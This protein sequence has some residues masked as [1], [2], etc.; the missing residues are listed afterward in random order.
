MTDLLQRT[1]TRRLLLGAAL[2]AAGCGGGGASPGN[3]G[4]TTTGSTSSATGGAGGGTTS[5][6]VAC[7][8]QPAN[9]ALGGT[10]AAYGQLSVK[11]MGMPGGAITICPADQV[12]AATLLLL[13]TATQNAADPT[14]IDQVS[15]TLCSLTLPTV[16]ALVGTCNPSSQALVSTQIIAPAGL[17]AALPKVA[18]AT[19]TGTVGG[20]TPGS[21]ITMSPLDVVV[22]STKSGSMM[23]SWNTMT[24]GCSASGIG[25]TNACDTACVADCASL[26][27][28]DMDGYPGVTV[29]VCGETQSDKNLTCNASMPSKA[30]VTLQGEAFIDIEVNPTFSGTAVSS[31]ELS[32]TVDSE[33]LYHVVGAD[34]YLAGAPISVASAI[35][36]LPTFQVDPSLSKFRMVRIDGQYGA[37]DWNVDPTQPSAACA[38]LNMMVNQL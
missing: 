1:G 35:E 19:T 24:S 9:L 13:V 12:G 5:T 6:A 20:T 23:P 33:V 22:G 18:T 3:G 17:I 34:V 2:L 30:G 26:R 25:N 37:P 32:G 4:G 15:A 10:W 27:D 7:T 21:S 31:C 36:S 14:K 38:T 29:Q 16:T 8:G 28:D 11:L